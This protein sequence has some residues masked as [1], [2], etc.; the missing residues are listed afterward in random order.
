MIIKYLNGLANPITVNQA[1]AMEEYIKQTIV[2]DKIKIEE[3]FVEQKLKHINYYLDNNENQ[4]QIRQQYSNHSITFFKN[5]VIND[6][7][8]KYDK[9]TYNLNDEFIEKQIVVFKDDS[10]IPIYFKSLNPITNE[11]IYFEKVY[12]DEQNDITYEFNY[13]NSIGNFIELTV[14]DPNNIVDTDHHIILPHEIGVGN[15]P[16]DFTWSGFEYYQYA[17]P[18]IPIIAVV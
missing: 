1:L 15:N 5:E 9:E 7:Y 10:P 12:H 13:D 3:T 11:L 2:N 17:E 18:V 4:N 6:I 8:K 14:F 16:Y